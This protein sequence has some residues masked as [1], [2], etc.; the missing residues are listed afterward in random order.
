MINNGV[1]DIMART[2]FYLTIFTCLSLC[3]SSSMSSSADDGCWPCSCSSGGEDC[4][5]LHP[6]LPCV[7]IG[8]DNNWTDHSGPHHQWGPQSQ[9]R[10][11][12]LVA[13]MGEGALHGTASVVLNSD[14]KV[15][16][17]SIARVRQITVQ[18]PSGN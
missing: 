3:L 11:I 12:C 1:S 17:R 16:G 15:V 4:C 7:A 14:E 10:L 5:G 8:R 18:L 6:C 9:D 13:E 2:L